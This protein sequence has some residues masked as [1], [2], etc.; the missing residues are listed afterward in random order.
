LT[1]FDTIAAIATPPGIGAV[2]IVRIS[3][4]QA[5]QVAD[6]CF[7]SARARKARA[8]QLR[9]GW[10]RDPRSGQRVDEALRADFFA[11]HSYTGED[12]VELHTHGGSGVVALCLS[13][14]LAAGARLAAAGEFTRRAF[15]NGRMD[16][17]Q[18]EAVADIISAE[19]RLAARAA[20]TRLEGILG[21]ALRSFGAQ[22]REF[23]IA[24]QAHVDYPDE[25]PP[26]DSGALQRCVH[27][28]LTRIDQL[29]AGA[30]AAQALRNGLD[31]VISGPPNAGKSSL[32]NALLQA[33]RA[34]VSDIPGTTRD[35]VEDSVAV[36]GVLLRLRDTAGLRRSA[37]ELEAQGIDRA[38]RAIAGAALVIVVIDGSRFPGADEIAA[39]EAT[40]DVTRIVL[41]NKA[42]LGERGVEQ[43]LALA[44]APPAARQAAVRGSVRWP[45]TIAALRREIAGLGWGG[46][47]DPGNALLANARQS[48]ALTRAREALEHAAETLDAAVPADLLSGD[49]AAA[50][51]A[52]G[53]L[54][55]EEV[56]AEV[57]DGIFARFC[58]GK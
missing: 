46:V 27:G 7:Q 26:P 48:A 30:D 56:S 54:T 53:E 44:A 21:S 47:T 52:Y 43:V 28:Q 15:L 37:D 25:V 31:C 6:A 12:V 2:A 11:P 57:L 51:S 49:L 10:V 17:A 38:R 16:L 42:D 22:L 35:I 41:C 24:I 8:A 32:L 20:A 5:R 33:E 29:L 58:V 4:P 1:A 19:S 55:G 14:V 36:D 3:G 40:R 13:C 50:L 18:A 39:L 23:L 45:A 9:R 34:I